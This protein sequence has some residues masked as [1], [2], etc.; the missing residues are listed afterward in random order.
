DAHRARLDRREP[1]LE[2]V[3]VF[4]RLGVRLAEERLA[5]VRPLVAETA[6]ETLH[7]GDADTHA[8]DRQDRVRAV[9]HDDAGLRERAHEIHRTVGLPVVVAEHRDDR[10]FQTAA[11]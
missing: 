5:E 11:G 6:D 4:R 9:E 8:P 10:Y 7:A 1:A 2:T 3:D